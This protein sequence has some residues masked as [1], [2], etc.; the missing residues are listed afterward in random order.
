MIQFEQEWINGGASLGAAAGWAADE[1]RLVSELGFALAEQG[2]NHEA[3]TIFEGLIALAPATTY[4]EVALGALW[5]R[6]N[7]P[8]RALPH[9]NAALAAD[10]NDI[11]TRVNRGE[12]FLRL[13]N[14]EGAKKDLKFVLRKRDKILTNNLLEQCFTR[15]RALL[16]TVERLSKSV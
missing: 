15:A 4:F 9:L 3:I 16:Y 12:V 8:A 10:P 11:P 5:L 6:E 14:Y 1:I 13:E 2:R 7:N